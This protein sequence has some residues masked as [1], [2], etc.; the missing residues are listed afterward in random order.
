MRSGRRGDKQRLKMSARLKILMFQKILI[1]N[2]GEIA[3]RIERTCREMGIP[4]VALYEASDQGSLHVR[5]ADECVRLDAPG[6]FMNGAAILEIARAKGADA[7]HPG[8]GFLAEDAGFIRACEDA[9]ITFIGPPSIV[10][11]MTANKIEALKRA[12]AAGIPTPEYLQTCFDNEESA[13]LHEEAEK[14][15]Y[16]LMVKSC[17]GGRGRGAHLVSHA[18]ELEAVVRRVQQES[19]AVYGDRRIYL[20]KEISPAQQ[21]AVQIVSDLQGNMIH[22]GERE[23]ALM[24]GNQK[25]IQESPACALDQTKREQLW[26]MALTVAQLFGYRNVGSVEFLMDEAGNLYFTEIKARIQTEHA[27]TEMLTRIDLVREQIRLAAGAPLALKQSDVKLD[28]WAMQ[29]RISAQDPQNHMMP[30]P[31]RLTRVRLPGGPE[32][33]AGTYVYSGCEVPPQYDPLIANLVVWGSDRENCRLR[34]ER[35]LGEFQLVGTATTLSLLQ[36]FARDADFV[37][38]E[39]YARSLRAHV[40]PEP[41][42]PRVLRDLAAAVAVY[43][44]RANQAFQPTTPDRINSGWHRTSRKLPE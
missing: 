41:V 5:M 43:D 22:L 38:G 32:V 28:G 33:R 20:E 24:L 35:A 4:S 44:Y 39:Y 6:G 9:G 31:G 14:L 1:A 11:E 2:R 13:P 17:R 37:R 8:Y 25:V 16:P 3:L 23:G 29:A 27:A 34:F 42:A 10:V 15:G 19:Q 12:R 36:Q 40:T 26:Q 7:I 21:F 30:S 18:E